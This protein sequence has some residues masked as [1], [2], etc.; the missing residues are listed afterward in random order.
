[1]DTI[2]LSTDKLVN[3]AQEKQIRNPHVK[4]WLH[5][6]KEAIDDA[7]DLLYQ[8]NTEA[9]QCKIEGQSNISKLLNPSFTW[10]AVFHNKV[11]ELIDIHD[12]LKDIVEQNDILGLK[13]VEKRYSPRSLDLVEDSDV[14]GR[15]GDKEGIVNLLVFDDGL[16]GNKISVIPIV[17]MAGIGKTTLA[18]LVYDDPRVENNYDLKEWFTVSEDFDTLTKRI[19]EAL[20]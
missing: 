1:M 7:E 13:E 10:L 2:L 20:T 18:Q 15:D 14:V 9:L 5:K 19:I 11:P 4:K 6:L 16:C 3:D 12:R 8:I 17:S